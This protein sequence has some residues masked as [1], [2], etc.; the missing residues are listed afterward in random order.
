MC[1]SFHVDSQAFI[2]YI[3]RV[4]RMPLTQDISVR[5]GGNLIMYGDMYPTDMAVV[6]APDRKGDI[7]VF[8]MIWGFTHEALSEPLVN[9]R[10]ETADKKELWKESW[11]K[12]RCVIPASWYYEWGV[13]ASEAESR[14]ADKYRSIRKRKYAIQPEGSEITY[15][16]GLYRF[17]KHGGMQ[18]PM[19]SIITREAVGT[20]KALHDRMP[21]IFGKESVIE[22]IQPS[23]DPGSIAERAVTGM[24]A[25]EAV[26][27][28]RSMLEFAY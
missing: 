7:S 11:Y 20:V 22:W 10:I 26:E 24:V 2:H 12:R 23:G 19:F 14:C 9:C 18:V 28:H 16:A 17:E 6:L 3:T 15:L 25:E 1:M 4:R 8:P 13:P 21:L 5:C 27:Y